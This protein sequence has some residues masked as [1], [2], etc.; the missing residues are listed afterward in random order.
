MST[1]KIKPSQIKLQ[2]LRVV[3]LPGQQ[4]SIEVAFDELPA[5]QRQTSADHIGW[6]A[7]GH[8]V[9]IH[10]V[11]LHPV[12]RTQAVSIVAVQLHRER[13]RTLLATNTAFTDGLRTRARDAALGQHHDVSAVGVAPERCAL[14]VSSLA[15]IS[16]NED[17]AEFRFYHV[18]GRA[19]GRLASSPQAHHSP[20]DIVI[21]DVCI[22]MPMAA[23]TVGLLA[24][25][26]EVF[27][28]RS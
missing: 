17:S 26:D 15:T 11:T 5:P 24:L 25:N 16:I 12:V 8:T 27:R 2:G 23:A 18:S 21:P 6:H 28:E 13:L 7:D 9:A 14:F 20:D 10:F 3:L 1:P 4:A 19:I 22:T